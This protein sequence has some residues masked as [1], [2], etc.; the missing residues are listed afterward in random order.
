M[1]GV[2][3]DKPTTAE[4]GLLRVRREMLGLTAE[5][6]CE[7]TPIG[8]SK[9]GDV[10]RGRTHGTRDKPAEEWHAPESVVAVMAMRLGVTPDELRQAGRPDAAEILEREA[11]RPPAPRPVPPVPP[12]EAAAD[13]L[14]ALLVRERERLGAGV[15]DRAT[16]EFLWHATDGDLNLK[17]IAERVRD[18]IGWVD[19]PGRLAA[20]RAV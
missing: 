17:P 10:E 12:S 4:G 15:N 11:A 2:T 7:G 14:F 5:Q 19:G 8:R 18:V 3:S 13:A 9:W 6:A 1:V 16:L 20:V